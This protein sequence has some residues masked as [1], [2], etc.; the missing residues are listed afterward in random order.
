MARNKKTETSNTEEMANAEIQ[1]DVAPVEA[2][3]SEE[4]P[5]AESEEVKETAKA[6]KAKKAEE[7]TD[8]EKELM[9]LYPHYE[10]V[11]ITPEGFVHPE[12]TPEY[13]RKGAKLLKNIFYNK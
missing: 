7:P 1:I 9:R 2:K 10:K 13:L 3:V 12:K 11:W 6:P 5:K 8:Q 4:E